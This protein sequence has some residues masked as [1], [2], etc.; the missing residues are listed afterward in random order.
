MIY[1]SYYLTTIQSIIHTLIITVVIIPCLLLI[2]IVALILQIY[3][4]ISTYIRT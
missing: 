2:F 3:D 4:N 1:H